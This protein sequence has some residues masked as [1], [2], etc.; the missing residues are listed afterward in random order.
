MQAIVEIW[1]KFQSRFLDLWNS[2]GNG[3]LY[4][5]SIYGSSGS[6]ALKVWYCPLSC[7]VLFGSHLMV[8]KHTSIMNTDQVHEFTIDFTPISIQSATFDLMIAT[9]LPGSPM[10]IS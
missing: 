3:D 8:I 9:L 1:E 5:Q 7:E 6:P 2:K 10:A 4:L